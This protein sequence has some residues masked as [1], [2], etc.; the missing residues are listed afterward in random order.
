M[1]ANAG[2]AASA[3]ATA[4]GRMTCFMIS[5]PIPESNIARLDNDSQGASATEPVPG[6]RSALLRH[7]ET[8]RMMR[9]MA[10]A[11]LVRVTRAAQSEEALELG[12]NAVKRPR[13]E[14]LRLAAAA[15]TLVAAPRIVSAQAYPA[16]P[17]RI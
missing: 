7:G 1:S 2:V 8:V 9:A 15:A 12:G 10:C 16:R 4:K 17:V 6:A 14:V 3:H 13:R 11:R 5:A